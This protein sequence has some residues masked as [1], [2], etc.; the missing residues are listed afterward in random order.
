MQHVDIHHI[1]TRVRETWLIGHFRSD[2]SWEIVVAGEEIPQPIC[3]MLPGFGIT[4]FRA[5]LDPFAATFSCKIPFSDDCWASFYG[6]FTFIDSLDCTLQR[7]RFGPDT[8]GFDLKASGTVEDEAGVSGPFSIAANVEFRGIWI[9]SESANGDPGLL[10]KLFPNA[11][12]R[13]AI[14]R[15]DK[16]FY[17]LSGTT[18]H[19][20]VEDS[21]A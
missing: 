20:L 7:D 18:Q 13:L 10:A 5:E 21:G 6:N 12:F 2:M 9:Y 15:K 14:A 8:P 4:Q 11:V 3:S 17:N 1:S 16:R 19:F